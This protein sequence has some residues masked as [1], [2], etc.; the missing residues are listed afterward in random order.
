MGRRWA[1]DGGDRRGLLAAALSAL[2]PGAGQCLVGRR[3]RGLVVFLPTL[4]LVA[5]G[6]ALQRL[7]AV[8]IAKLLVRPSV[9]VAVAVVSLAVAAWR[10]AA[11]VDAYHVAVPRH[12]RVGPVKA[13]VVALAAL[14]AL[15][16]LAGIS[17]ALRARDLLTSVFT[18]AEEPRLVVDVGLDAPLPRL[19]RRL[20]AAGALRR[21]LAADDLEAYLE[22]PRPL[23]ALSTYLPL[24]ERLPTDRLTILLVGGDAGP[25]REGLRTDTMIVMSVDLETGRTALFGIPRNF[26]N[27]PL[28]RHLRN[29]F[30]GLER[31]VREY[32]LSDEDGDGYTD[33]WTDLD[34]DGVPDEPP[35][36]SCHCFADMLNKVYR[37]TRDWYDRYP[38]TPD[39]GM[40]AL[41]DVLAHLLDLPI[42]YYVLVDMGAFVDLVDAV[43]GVDVYVTEP[44]HVRVSAP[45]EGAPKAAISV[46][47]GW[48]HLSGLE[49]LAWSRWRIGSSDYARMKRQRCLVRPFRA[50]ADPLDLFR[51]FPRIA[52]VLERSVV[53]DVP[54]NALPDLVERLAAIDFDDIVTVGFVPPRY[55]AGRTP[56]RYPIPDVPKIRRTVAAV[57]AGDTSPGTTRDGSSE[58]GF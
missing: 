36:E 24:R 35:F 10:A 43:G 11:V 25:G 18:A 17:Y 48:H 22:D 56:K 39:P 30:I 23:R 37:E 28:P 50:H 29:S 42:D 41:R 44:M 9:L 12:R 38:N 47:P 13:G 58:C 55:N 19:E 8:G 7:G 3:F 54:L 16:H 14:V 51:R 4:V 57:L 34:G 52:D 45:R 49:A 15:P 21:F 2:V 33:A 32:D 53:T 40:A 27:V 5:A 31:R 46:E 6:V 20:T 1:S 26:K